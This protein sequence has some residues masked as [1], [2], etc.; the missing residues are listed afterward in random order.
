MDNS[1]STSELSNSDYSEADSEHTFI[2]SNHPQNG[3]VHDNDY[4]N[5]TKTQSKL[6]GF[7]FFLFIYTIV[8]YILLLLLI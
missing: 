1:I 4:I 7:F 2:N 5:T 8:N 6:K 3:L